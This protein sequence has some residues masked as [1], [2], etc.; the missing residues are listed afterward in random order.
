MPDL[1][2]WRRR[3]RL[4]QAAAADLLGVS[5]PYLSLVELGA[6]PFTAALRNRM[7]QLGGDAKT[8]VPD[9]R[10]RAQLSRL[11]YPGF[12][13]V[14]KTG[15]KPRPDT[16]LVTVLSSPDAD[17]RVV[18]ALPWVVQTF[19]RELD[20]GLIV[21][22]SKLRNIQNRVGFLL[23]VSGVRTS[24]GVLA[25]RELDRA[26]LLAEDTL[27]WGS[28]PDPIRDWMRA[29]RSERAAHWNV[30]TRLQP[31]PVREAA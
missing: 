24:G 6:R 16:L 22:E 14:T 5:Q 31:E 4:T 28:M 3:N 27:C 13:H 19:E 21:R 2:T 20:F 23:E 25:V 17:A 9:A 26:R 18:E 15:R 29:N 11:G 10:F 8:G 30:V 12:A 7:K 1:S